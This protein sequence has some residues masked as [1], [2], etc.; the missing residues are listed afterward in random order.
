MLERLSEGLAV[1]GYEV[2]VDVAGER[3]P[4]DYE[5]VHLFNLAT[6][7][8]TQS[9]AQRAQAAGVPFVV[10]S[11]YEDLPEFHNQSHAIA[12]TLLDYVKGGQDRNWW[13]AHRI[14]LSDLGTI[15]RSQR[16]P[17]DWIVQNAAALF[18][19]GAGEARALKRDYPQ[20][21]AILELP[22]GHEA[23][24]YTHLTLPTKRIV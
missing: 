18:A 22:L 16:F 9:L 19:N 23:V 15:A 7:Q 8:L 3:N 2:T 24:S 21:K 17:A 14:D 4:Q 6:T 5:V 13:R 12:A 10:T 1:R 11:L 20:A